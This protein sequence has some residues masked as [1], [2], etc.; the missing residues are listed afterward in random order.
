[1]AELA[2][3]FPG[4]L[5]AL[6]YP[7]PGH[8]AEQAIVA[9]IDGVPLAHAARIAGV[10]L[11]LRKLP[12]EMFSDVLPRLPDGEPL[13]RQIV[14]HLPRSPKLA[15]L[16]FRAVSGAAEWGHESLAVWIARELIRDP[17]RVEFDRLRLIGLWAWF[18]NRLDTL[19]S[20]L[21]NRTWQPA[22]RFNTARNTA[23][24]WRMTVALHLN[25]GAEPIR[26]MWLQPGSVAG[27]D[28]VPLRTVEHFIEEAT[29]MKNCLK[30]FGY[31]VAHNRSRFWSIRKNGERVATLRVAMSYKDPL[32]TVFELRAARNKDAPTEVWWAA[33]QWLHQHDLLR[34]DTKRRDWGTV[35]LN[36]SMWKELWRPY[37]LAKRRIP[38]W[39][40]LVP[41]R[42]AL[43]AL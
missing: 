26:D 13:R 28:F 3:S 21:F 2:V 39:L 7:R 14:N 25:L 5:A 30:T 9:V 11:W 32:L 20:N 29:M 18:S 36:A 27:F 37:W 17:K 10:P 22:M 41:S 24:D 1:V 34:I 35:P 38:S 12:A 16:W 15:P 31:N 8:D 40:P 33:R 43:E 42:N 6:A 23:E 19:G 4:L